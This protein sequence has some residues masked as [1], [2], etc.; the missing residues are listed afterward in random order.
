MKQNPG[1]Y[2]EIMDQIRT[3][4]VVLK[5]KWIF[6]VGS[7]LT[8]I[9]ILT[10]TFLSISLFHLVMIRMRL[11]APF[12]FLIFGQQGILP[13]VEAFPFKYLLGALVSTLAGLYLIRKKDFSYQIHWSLLVSGF[14]CGIFV[15]VLGVHRAGLTG[16]LLEHPLTHDFYI[17]P[18]HPR[19]WYV[20]TIQKRHNQTLIIQTLEKSHTINVIWSE[21][22]QLPNGADFEL[23]E[24]VRVVGTWKTY[25]FSASGIGRVEMTHP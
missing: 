2:Q 16:T 6:V 1:I 21:K 18:A 25:T 4:E 22:T 14:M 12:G 20:G 23:G 9:G 24:Q 8:F 10:F 7:A 11:Y 15:F 3:E 19:S 13:F 17:V 5:P